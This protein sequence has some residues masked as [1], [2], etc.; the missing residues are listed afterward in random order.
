M[1]AGKEWKEGRQGGGTEGLARRA[2]GAGDGQENG[3]YAAEEQLQLGLQQK[4]GNARDEEFDSLK[5]WEEVFAP[6]TN[7]DDG[8]PSVSCQ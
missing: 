8:T 4:L 1:G 2:R 6:G 7:D 5:F 3:W